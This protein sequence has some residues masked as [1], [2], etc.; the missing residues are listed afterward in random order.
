MAL[1]AAGYNNPNSAYQVHHTIPLRESYEIHP[2]IDPIAV[3]RNLH[4]EWQGD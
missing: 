3:R 4:A 1:K 2:E